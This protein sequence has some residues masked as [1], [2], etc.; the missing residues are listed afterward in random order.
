MLD[1]TVMLN[2]L[3]PGGLTNPRIYSSHSVKVRNESVNADVNT[4]EEFLET[5]D[6]LVVEENHLPEQIFNIERNLLFKK[7]KPKRTV[8]HNETR[9]GPDSK[10]LRTG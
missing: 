7:Q 8:V 3:A 6:K 9:S 1:P 10:L 4:A 2:L 5:L